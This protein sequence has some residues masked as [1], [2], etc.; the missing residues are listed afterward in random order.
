[1]IHVLLVCIVAASPVAA[2]SHVPP[3]DATD[4]RILEVCEGI[5]QLFESST[6]E[7]WSGFNLHERPF[8]VYRPGKWALLLAYAGEAPGF[9]PYPAEWPELTVAARLHF[10]RCENLAGQ[11]VFDFPIGARRGVAIG[12]DSDLAGARDVTGPPFEATLLGYIVH[13]AFHQYQN[14]QF[15]EMPSPSEERYP[16]LDAENSSLAALEMRLLASAVDA[17]SRDDEE[18]CAQATKRFVAVRQ[19]RWSE[20]DPFVEP[21]ERALELREGTAKYV[22]VKAVAL[23]TKARYAAHVTA[24]R[25]L[26]EKLEGVSLAGLLAA[27]F[28][29]RMTEGAVTPDDMPRNRVYPVAAAQCYLLDFLEVDWKKTAQRAEGD[30]SYAALLREHLDVSD[31]DLERSLEE[32]MEIY[33][34]EGIEAATL[35]QNEKYVRGFEAALAAFENK[36]GQRIEVTIPTNGASRSRVS[37]VRRWL[38]DGGR[39]SLCSAYEIYVLTLPGSRLEIRESGVLE[40][41]HWEGCTRTAITFTRGELEVGIDGKPTSLADGKAIEFASITLRAPNVTLEASRP[42]TLRCTGRRVLVDLRPAV[43][44]QGRQ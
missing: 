9:E 22:E 1:M 18:T 23:A 36:E 16:I 6:D 14:E 12:V 2:Q 44:H 33:D 41:N 31:N 10:G 8:V 25:P 19:L 37:H 42:G 38:M 40:L 11:L 26:A 17:A 15:G 27:D 34:E 32:A 30:F 29:A 5:L 39:R 35:A 20:A 4:M 7:I 24:E 13:E 43:R 21:F 28:A 3:P